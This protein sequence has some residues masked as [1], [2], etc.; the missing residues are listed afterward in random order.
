MSPHDPVF[1]PELDFASRAPGASIADELPPEILQIIGW[2]N[3]HAVG[4]EHCVSAASL[5]A[6]LGIGDAEGRVVRN[7]ISQYQEH[8]PTVVCAMPGHGYFVTV[9]TADM[10]QYEQSLLSV[11]KS[12]GARVRSFRRNASR[13][14]YDRVGIGGGVSRYS[15]RMS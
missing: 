2:L 8:F 7:L 10:E 4:V 6:A 15:L 12:L 9:D 13:C 14:G 1:Q 5:A 3:R 11:L